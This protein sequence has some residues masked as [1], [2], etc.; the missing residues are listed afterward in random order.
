LPA[1]EVAEK[2]RGAKEDPGPSLVAPEILEAAFKAP[3]VTIRAIPLTIQDPTGE[4]KL[5]PLLL[6][7]PDL[8]LPHL[9][10]DP[11]RKLPTTPGNERE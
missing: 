3:L 5:K 1:A 8:P 7:P 9:P 2:E 6:Q 4:Q 10:V 11:R